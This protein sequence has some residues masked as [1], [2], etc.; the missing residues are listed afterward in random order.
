MSPPPMYYSIAPPAE[1]L[2]PPLFDSVSKANYG[3]MASSKPSPG[4]SKETALLPPN[5]VSTV[6]PMSPQNTAPVNPGPE[7]PCWSAWGTGQFTFDYLFTLI[8]SSMS[9]ES[10]KQQYPDHYMDVVFKLYVMIECIGK[11]PDGS[12]SPSIFQGFYHLKRLFPNGLVAAQDFRGEVGAT[13]LL[14]VFALGVTVANQAINEQ[15]NLNLDWELVCGIRE[16]DVVTLELT[17]LCALEADVFDLAYNRSV[18]L[19]W[20]GHLGY[21]AELYL[22]TTADVIAFVHA[23]AFSLPRSKQRNHVH[24]IDLQTVEHL[25]FRLC[26]E[27]GL[28]P[29][30]RFNSESPSRA[31]RTSR[32]LRVTASDVLEAVAEEYAHRLHYP[33]SPPP[34]SCCY[35]GDSATA[36]L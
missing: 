22:R 27:T 2:P 3:G 10:F 21:Y 9:S 8:T 12:P 26:W 23:Q 30:M 16:S 6:V 14:R 29:T 18:Y 19:N 20:L 31:R 1:S 4:P 13:L 24:P 35:S 15:R 7:C 11:M 33:L 34:S 25:A 17:A 32:I 28:A 5:C 36:R